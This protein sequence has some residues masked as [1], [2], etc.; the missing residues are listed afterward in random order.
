MILSN[1]VMFN[2][3]FEHQKQNRTISFCYILEKADISTA[4]ISD[5]W[6]TQKNKIQKIQL[7]FLNSTSGM[8]KKMHL[9]VVVNRI[10]DVQCIQ[11][12]I[13]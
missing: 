2:L 4:D 6:Q 12:E 7:L 13:S 5:N 9:Y 1:Q 10:I 3:H 11:R 8:A